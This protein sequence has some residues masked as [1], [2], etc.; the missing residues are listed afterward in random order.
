MSMEKLPSLRSKFAV[1]VGGR[2]S[3]VHKEVTAGDERAIWPHQKS[4]NSQQDLFAYADPPRNR[5]TD[6][7]GTNDLRSSNGYYTLNM[8]KRLSA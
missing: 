7:S 2:D 4:A 3:A 1:P 6:R 8:A 5:L